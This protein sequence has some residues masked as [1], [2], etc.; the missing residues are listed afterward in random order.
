M[1][2]RFEV[3]KNRAEADRSNHITSILLVMA[4]VAIKV[5][6]V[7]ERKNLQYEMA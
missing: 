4:T 2:F 3:P 1:T 6:S 7:T 5:S